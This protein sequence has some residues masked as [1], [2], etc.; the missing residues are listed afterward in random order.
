M[1]GLARDSFFVLQFVRLGPCRRTIFVRLEASRRSP[2]GK[3]F[4]W[5]AQDEGI[6]PWLSL[7][8]VGCCFV[9]C[10]SESCV[11][12]RMPKFENVGKFQFCENP[13]STH[14]CSILLVWRPPDERILRLEGPRRTKSFVWRPQDERIRSSGGLQ[15]MEEPLRPQ[16]SSYFAFKSRTSTTVTCIH[17]ERYEHRRYRRHQHSLSGFINQ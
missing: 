6:A 16:Q 13:S 2:V 14:V 17:L 1:L 11:G 9:S 7:K 3:S 12:A 15:T 10:P 5:R 8:R 4:V